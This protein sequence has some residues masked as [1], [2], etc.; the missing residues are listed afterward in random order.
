[1][2][3]T[4]GD[5]ST[6]QVYDIAQTPGCYNEIVTLVDAA[7]GLAVPWLT[8]N[9]SS[10]TGVINLPQSFD[11]AII[12]THSFTLT[13][14]VT[15]P[16]DYTRSTFTDVTQSETFTVEILDP[17][18]NTVLDTLTAGD[19]YYLVEGTAITQKLP[20]G[21]SV[22]TLFGFQI[23]GEYLYEFG[24]VYQTFPSTSPTYQ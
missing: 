13:K 2:Q 15:Q 16:D 17:C 21:D 14:K 24:S 3:V 6:S 22:S 20:M 1:M 9:P 7:T 18:L 12:G 23:C 19:M 4:L 11:R 10:G 5:A 8:V